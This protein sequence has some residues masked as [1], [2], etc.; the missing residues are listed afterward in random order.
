MQ[1]LANERRGHGIQPLAENTLGRARIE[2]HQK[3]AALCAIFHIGSEYAKP[4][5]FHPDIRR[6]GLL[7]AQT[8]RLAQQE[9]RFSGNEVPRGRHCGP[10]FNAVKLTEYPWALALHPRMNGTDLL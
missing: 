3:A 2:L 10:V 5:A 9:M 8:I 6:G 7:Q 4:P 1:P